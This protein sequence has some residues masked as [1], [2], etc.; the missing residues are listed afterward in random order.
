MGGFIFGNFPKIFR[1]IICITFLSPGFGIKSIL[2]WIGSEIWTKGGVSKC[3]VIDIIGYQV[4]V[5]SSG[6][7]VEI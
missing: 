2:K 4:I 7:Q 1:K 6:H 3:D 5:N